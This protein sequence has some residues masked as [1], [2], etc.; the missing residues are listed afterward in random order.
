MIKKQNDC[1]LHH[2]LNER[3]GYDFVINVTLSKYM[4]NVLL[5]IKHLLA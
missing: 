2:I 3:I 4:Y 1:A 5:H